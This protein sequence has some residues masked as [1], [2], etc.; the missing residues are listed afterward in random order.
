MSDNSWQPGW[1][2]NTGH[3]VL[4]NWTIWLSIADEDEEP[5]YYL[6]LVELELPATTRLDTVARKALSVAEMK[7]WDFTHH[8]MQ[9][10]KG[11]ALPSGWTRRSGK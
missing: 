5:G 10:T 9:I 3:T 1:R 7:G 6:E 2:D 11:E 8:E 4:H